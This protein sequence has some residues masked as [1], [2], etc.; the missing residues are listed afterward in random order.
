MRVRLLGAA[1]GGGFPQWNCGCDNCRAARED[2]RR[3]K[4]R[5]QSC[6]AVSGD[7][8]R[9]FLVNAS[10]DLRSQVESFRALGPPAG[11][12]RGTGIAGVLL[13]N[14]D[15][16][17]TLGLLLLREGE[18][19][20]VHA[21][22]RV[23]QAL[24]TGLNLDAVLGEYCGIEWREPPTE[25]APLKDGLG[26]GSGLSYCAFHVPGKPPRYLPMALPEAGDAVGYRFVDPCTGGRLVVLPDVAA[27]DALVER[28]IEDCDLLLLDGTFYD[29][30]E[31][32]RRGVGTATAAQMG[33]LSIGGAGGSLHHIAAIPKAQR[34]YM[35]VNNT[36]AILLEDSPQRK[37]VEAAGITVGEAG[38]EFE[39]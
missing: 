18:R 19:L 34:V 16:D 23:R 37:A 29:D 14:A 24:N 39:L 5:T 12:R 15:L 31:M 25:L 2:A 32:L 33:H 7:G 36:N 10:P 20:V 22:S 13:T 9:W 28:Q 30:D 21:T 27:I 8:R 1:A 35:H 38:M 3:A 6:V 26:D 11:S 17:H 4:P